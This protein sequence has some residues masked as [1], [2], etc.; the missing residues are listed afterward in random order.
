MAVEYC[1]KVIV[2]LRHVEGKAK[3]PFSHGRSRSP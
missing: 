3:S 1:S 2:G